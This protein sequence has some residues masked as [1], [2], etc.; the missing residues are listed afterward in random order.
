MASSC[1]TGRV[2][3]LCWVDAP[4]KTRR[5]STIERS[6]LTHLFLSCQMVGTEL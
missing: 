1:G 3:S 5:P 6:G 2:W 4:P